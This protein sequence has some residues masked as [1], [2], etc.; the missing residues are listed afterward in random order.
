MDNEFVLIEKNIYLIDL[1]NF[2]LDKLLDEFLIIINKLMK[3]NDHDV[4]LNMQLQLQLIL[5]FHVYKRQDIVHL[6]VDDI[7]Q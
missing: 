2:D 7:F 1:N 3:E 5:I 4:K 6:F